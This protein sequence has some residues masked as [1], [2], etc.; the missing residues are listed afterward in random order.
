VLTFSDLQAEIV[1]ALL[2]AGLEVHPFNQRDVA[3][4]LRM[5]RTPGARVGAAA[6]AAGDDG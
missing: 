1:A 6:Q 2:R 4:I 5:I 3:G